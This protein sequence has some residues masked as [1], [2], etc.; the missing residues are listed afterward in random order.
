MEVD[1]GAALSVISKTTYDQLWSKESAPPLK[2]TTA[3]LKTYTGEHMQVVGSISVEVEHNQQK[4]QLDLI[5]VG[6]EGPSLMGRDW[7]RKITLTCWSTL[8][9]ASATTSLQDVLNEHSAVFKEE[10]VLVQGTEAKIHV[11][12]EAKPRFCKPRPVPY[13][14]GGPGT[15]SIRDG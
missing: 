4:K 11:D 8:H 2:P 12:P 5:V 9:V 3:K 6:G 14:E 7:L 10:L 1:T 13:G 15:E